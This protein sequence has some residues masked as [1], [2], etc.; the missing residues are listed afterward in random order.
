M[1]SELQKLIIDLHQDQAER[2]EEILARL[3]GIHD[4]LVRLLGQDSATDPA[5]G[6]A[7]S[8]DINVPDTLAQKFETA[9]SES[10]GTIDTFPVEEGL[11][12]F[13]EFFKEVNEFKYQ[14][15]SVG[16]A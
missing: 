11:N 7:G 12:A 1:I 8:I 14:S 2:L 6:L 5:V 3:S 9:I 4:Q 10:Y 15:V 13:F 16:R